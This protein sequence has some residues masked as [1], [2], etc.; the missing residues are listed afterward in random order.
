MNRG[1]IMKSP[2]SRLKRSWSAFRRDKRGSL[3][4]ETGFVIP[5]LATM[6]L[7][8]IEVAR[9]ALLQQKL[10]RL[11]TTTSDMVSQ[12]EAISV[13]DINVILTATTS[14]MNP[15]T[16]GAEGVVVITSV[17]ATGAL[18]PKIDWQRSGGGSLSGAVSK[19]GSPGQNATLPP[20]FLVRSGENVIISET[21]YQFTPMFVS[22][23][24]SQSTLYHSA[25]FRPRLSSLT[26]LNP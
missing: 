14:I 9:Y 13:A 10:D 26:T 11:A 21:F 5:V 18:P 8:G 25:F 7:G 1:D 2:I 22:S 6:T 20:G 4:I 15:F 17:S 23:V 24:V 16:F 3:L 19:I 12:S